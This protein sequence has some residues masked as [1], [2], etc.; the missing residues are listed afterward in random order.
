VSIQRL[1]TY[2]QVPLADLLQVFTALNEDGH[3]Q[4]LNI[5]REYLKTSMVVMN[6]SSSPERAR[7]AQVNFR[8][9]YILTNL[10]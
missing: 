6:T 5:G 10:R 9:S 2:L 1:S 3:F 8:T 7:T 4:L